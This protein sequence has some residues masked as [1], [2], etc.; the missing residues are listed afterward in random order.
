M[1]FQQFNKHLGGTW[2]AWAVTSPC[3]DCRPKYAGICTNSACRGIAASA[4][5]KHFLISTLIR[6]FRSFLHH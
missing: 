4:C 2:S 5:G 3:G 6:S 1:Q